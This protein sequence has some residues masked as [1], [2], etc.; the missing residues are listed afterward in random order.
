MNVHWT[1]Y[2]V[3]V[4]FVTAIDESMSP[5]DHEGLECWI[6]LKC[7]FI[8]CQNLTCVCQNLNCFYGHTILK[9]VLKFRLPCY[10]RCLLPFQSLI[11]DM[12]TLKALLIFA[13][14]YSSHQ[15]VPPPPS[16]KDV[17]EC[18]NMPDDPEACSE[19]EACKCFKDRCDSKAMD[20]CATDNVWPLT[21]LL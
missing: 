21:F 2:I 8:V 6:I 19:H 11:Q 3:H 5:W 17:E 10:I 14:L 9:H 16:C 18:Y 20:N 4:I 15:D 1:L 13:L 7:Y 12:Q